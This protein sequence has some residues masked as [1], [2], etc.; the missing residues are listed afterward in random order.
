MWGGVAHLVVTVLK[1][2]GLPE[3]YKHQACGTGFRAGFLGQSSTAV[4]TPQACVMGFRAQQHSGLNK[5]S[6]FGGLVLLWQRQHSGD[7]G[8]KGATGLC[9]LSRHCYNICETC[10]TVRFAAQHVIHQAIHVDNTPLVLHVVSCTTF[11][12]CRPFGPPGS[13]GTASV[14]GVC[15]WTGKT[16]RRSLSLSLPLS[17]SLC[18][19]PLCEGRLQ[20]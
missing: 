14:E 17:L 9:A 2:V 5:D 3:R 20:H 15:D 16:K 10:R 12:T 4:H 18:L 13:R 19:S 7:A 8:G 6:G 11:P 1:Q